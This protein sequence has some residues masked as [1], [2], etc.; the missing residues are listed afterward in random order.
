MPV[1]YKERVGVSGYTGSTI[2]AAVLGFKMLPLM[3]KY[4]LKKK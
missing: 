2:R 4:L 3:F 1:I